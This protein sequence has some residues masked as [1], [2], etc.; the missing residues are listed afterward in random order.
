MPLGGI[1]RV[2]YQPASE[3]VKDTDIIMI[4]NVKEKKLFGSLFS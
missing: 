3:I 2:A 1:V 4:F